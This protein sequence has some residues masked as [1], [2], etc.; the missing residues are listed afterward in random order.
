MLRSM[1]SSLIQDGEDSGTAGEPSIGQSFDA[2]VSG[3]KLKNKFVFGS[4]AADALGTIPIRNATELASYFNPNGQ[5]A[6]TTVINQEW[7]YYN[8]D[9]AG[10]NHVFASDALELTG[11]LPNGALPAGVTT[12]SPTANVTYSRQ[13]TVAD[14][15]A[16]KVGQ[17]VGFGAEA[18][19]NL[20]RMHTYSITTPANGD[21]ITLVLAHVLTAAQGGFD[22]VTLNVTSAG[23]AADDAAAMVAAVNA[24][25]TLQA[26]NITALLMP[27]VP[28]GFLTSFPKYSLSAPDDF[29]NA[30]KGSI[31][32][33]TRTFSRTGTATILNPQNVSGVNYIVSKSSNT[34]TLAH[35]VTL[36]TSSVL[37]FNPV[38][39][40]EIGFTGTAGGVEHAVN[41][42]FAADT[43]WT[44][45]AG[46][47]IS[48]GT[49]NATTSNAALSQTIA[50]VTSGASYKVTYT[51]TRSA[52]SVRPSLGGVNGTSR[53][54]SGTYTDTITA[55]AGGVLAFTGTGFTGTIDVVSVKGNGA[56]IVQDVSNLTIGQV[57]QCAFQD[58][59]L[60][61]IMAIDAT[62]K[63]IIVEGAPYMQ[64]GHW[65][66]AYP[67]IKAL[68]S[69]ASRTNLV[70][71]NSS[72]ASAGTL[73]GGETDPNGA[74]LAMLYTETASSTG[75]QWSVGASTISYVSGT[76]YTASAY[77]KA[78]TC[79]RVQMFVSSSVVT[80]GNGYANYYL[81][82]AGSVSVT[83][84][85]FSSASIERLGATDWYRIVAT[86]TCNNT[87]SQTLAFCTLITGLET[88][89]PVILGTSRT[90]Y[91]FGPQLEAGSFV[92]SYIPTTTTSSNLSKT[93]IFS[94]VPSGVAV[95][96]R[97][98]DYYGAAGVG[99]IK[100]AAKDATTVTLDTAVTVGNGATIQFS[101]PISSGQIWSK[102]IFAPGFDGLSTV[103]Y[104]ATIK[105]PDAAVI[106]AW[107]AY[108]IYSAADDPNPTAGGS[109]TSEV[110]FADVFNYWDNA[111]TNNY[112]GVGGATQTGTM[113]AGSTST[114]A[115]LATTSNAVNGD[116]VGMTLQ[117]TGGTGNGQT[118]TITG[119]D[120]ATRTATVSPAWTTTPD[121]TTTYKFNAVDFYTHPGWANGS[122][123]GNNFGAF[124]RRLSCIMTSTKVF[125]YL[126]NV[127]I[128]A[129]Y[130]TWNRYK[131]AQ[132]GLDLAVGSAKTNFN[133]NGFYPTDVSQFPMK[134]RIKD[135]TWWADA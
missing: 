114:T 88:R 79:D 12:A 36:T 21:V 9:M 11:L 44:K 85:G 80:S 127:L 67:V 116:Y 45:G 54:T 51:V 102:A 134:F 7:Q 97:F 109:G 63:E 4:A 8:T 22:P 130:A 65:L 128:R 82:G 27:N 40:M 106:A 13:V 25:A 113:Q 66:T 132:V 47:T 41:G 60:R 32:W 17:V 99:N 101:P 92:S 81:N 131:R 35:P 96:Q 37:T 135:V 122:L 86:F 15:S 105:A 70:L 62:N 108:W 52:G 20:H 50:E 58:S 110:D 57:V 73:T 38:Y 119:Y 98:M 33:M 69:E 23:V 46:W 103:A 18:F 72:T 3:L 39:M 95:G 107:P 10:G 19:S 68:T 87:A 56:Y 121:A 74:S 43:D 2:Y 55:G 100:V 91:W 6:G 120:G 84:A 129:V 93:L 104:D 34:L 61:R 16:L 26:W 83:G 77:V 53:S 76:T 49:A 133:S 24:H 64:S 115:V 5:A 111:S 90:M 71:Y 75:Q 126:D 48:A 28:G 118:R 94:A 59:N 14:A 123:A 124:E 125:F 42:G 78:G 112:L 1:L 117:T 30:G 31:A 29:G 89:A